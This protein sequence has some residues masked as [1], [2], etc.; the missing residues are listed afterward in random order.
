MKIIG[1]TGGTGAG[2]TTA[3]HA[4]KALHAWIIDADRVYHDLTRENQN[5][6]QEL[7][8]RFGTIYSEAG[9]DRKKLGNIVFNDP[10]ALED[11]NK[12]THR[13]VGEEIDRQL[14]L[15]RA[16]ERPIAAIDAIGLL[17]SGLFEKC[18]ATVAV[19]APVELRIHRVMAREGISEDYAR[20]RVMAQK[21]EAFFRSRCDYILE[22]TE[23]DTPER[24]GARAL[25]LFQQIL[26]A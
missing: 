2:K 14:N 1:I 10:E 16:E 8:Q 23:E 22:N 17:E 15:A 25:A 24:F 4:L 26:N 12:L 13:Y 9:L 21:D 5:L 18:D 11:L 20:M 7:E 6:R 19:I 3:L